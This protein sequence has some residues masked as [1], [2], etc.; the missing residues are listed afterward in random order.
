MWYPGNLGFVGLGKVFHI[1]STPGLQESVLLS[2]D[3]E[4]VCAFVSLI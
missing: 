3:S 1:E 2:R 4:C